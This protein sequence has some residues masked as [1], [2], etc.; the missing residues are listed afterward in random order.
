[1]SQK[2]VVVDR[3]LHIG[4]DHKC[5]HSDPKDMGGQDQELRST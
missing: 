4:G 5:K 3:H 2:V 1:M